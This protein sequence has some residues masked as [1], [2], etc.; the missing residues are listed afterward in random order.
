LGIPG[1]KSAALGKIARVLAETDPV[2]AAGLISD[3]VPDEWMPRAAPEIRAL[4]QDLED[5]VAEGRKR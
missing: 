3:E 1:D 5:P 2:R 4:F